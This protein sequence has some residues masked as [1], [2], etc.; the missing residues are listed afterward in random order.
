MNSVAQTQA[1]GL[2]RG[3][4]VVLLNS[5]PQHK[6]VVNQWIDKFEAQIPSIAYELFRAGGRNTR[7]VERALN[8]VDKGSLSL[9]YLGGF[10][11]WFSFL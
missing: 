2:A 8:L 10:F 9:E 6:A 4:I 1:T 7:S 5:S 11:C 3:Y